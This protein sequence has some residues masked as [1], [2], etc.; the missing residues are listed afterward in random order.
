MLPTRVYSEVLP[1]SS[2]SVRDEATPSDARPALVI[3]AAASELARF[4]TALFAPLAA[5]DTAD[6][7]RLIERWRPR[8]VAVDW[9]LADFD[10]KE[11]CAAAR[12]R[13]G[14]AIF[15]TMAAPESAPSAL[16]AGCHTLL[17]KP[18]TTNLIA[19]RLGRLSR[20]LPSGSAATR[21]AEKFGQSGTNRTWPEIACPKCAQAG[22]VSFEYSSHRRTW[23]ACMSCE[24]V[25]LGRRQE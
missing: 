21:V 3:A 17:L 1:P 16:K 14:T 9:D 19:A 7:I 20:E 5:R 11:I 6:A 24:S 25:W 12:E 18:L 13:P 23:Y 10:G 2:G 15:V 8:V 4:P 22:A